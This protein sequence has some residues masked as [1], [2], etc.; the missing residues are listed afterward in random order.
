MNMESLWKQPQYGTTTDIMGKR[1]NLTAWQTFTSL[2]DSPG[3]SHRSYSFTSGIDQT[4]VLPF[5]LLVIQNYHNDH[6]D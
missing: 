3:N 1:S 4:E 5:T 2:A 6:S